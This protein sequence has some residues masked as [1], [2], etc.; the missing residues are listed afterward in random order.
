MNATSS[1][2]QQRY[3][4]LP[5]IFFS[6]SPENIKIHS[7]NVSYIFPTK[8]VFLT[9]WEM[10]LSSPKLKTYIFC[11]KLYFR[12]NFPSVKNKNFL[13]FSYI[14]ENGTFQP[15]TLKNSYIFSNNIFSLSVFNFLHQIH[16][17]KFLCH[18]QQTQTS[19][20]L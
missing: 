1:S 18:Q 6:P 9:F 7:E 10:E 20:F 16:Q 17:K 2:Q 4:G 14:S 8:I 19:F 12:T 13:H 11:K 5:G 3:I 15:Q